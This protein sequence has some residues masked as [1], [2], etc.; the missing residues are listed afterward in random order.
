[1]PDPSAA[2]DQGGPMRSLRPNRNR[3]MGTYDVS[4]F[5]D[6]GAVGIQSP[7]EGGMNCCHPAVAG[8]VRAERP[9][10]VSWQSDTRIHECMVVVFMISDR[11]NRFIFAGSVGDGG[12]AFDK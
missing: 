11:R 6:R 9:D 2:E 5:R 7:L 4:T 10:R 1:M 3:P 12:A 8:S